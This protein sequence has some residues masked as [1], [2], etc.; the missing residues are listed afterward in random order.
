MKKRI[1]DWYE[2]M[3]YVKSSQLDFKIV[4]PHI[5]FNKPA[6]PLNIIEFSKTLDYDLIVDED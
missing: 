3:D 2:R 6:C 5:V 1:C 4:N